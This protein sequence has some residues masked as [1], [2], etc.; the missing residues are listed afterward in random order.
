M[1][2][3]YLYE[4]YVK[5]ISSLRGALKINQ[6]TISKKEIVICYP[7][8]PDFSLSNAPRN[9][10]IQSPGN[11]KQQDLFEISIITQIES[12]YNYFQPLIT[13]LSNK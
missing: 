13:I 2:S 5:S 8:N 6:E 4:M 3:V 9:A 12:I 10:T 1:L 11:S 7:Q